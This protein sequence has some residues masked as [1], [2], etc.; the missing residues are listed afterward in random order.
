MLKRTM[1]F[2]CFLLIPAAIFASEE[3]ITI[4]ARQGV[5]MKLLIVSAETQTDKALIMFPGGNGYE[6]FRSHAGVITK[7]KNFLVRTA[8]YFARKGFLFP[9]RPM[10]GNERTRISG[11]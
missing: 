10:R 5:T 3:I 2:V 11:D 8:P 4:D 7:G 9:V 6:H 1:L